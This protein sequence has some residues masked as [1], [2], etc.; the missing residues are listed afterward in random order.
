[1]DT[2]RTRRP[3]AGASKLTISLAVCLAVASAG[4]TVLRSAANPELVA[5][6]EHG[7][8]IEISDA[9]ESLID[10]GRDT[11][12]DREYAWEAV[13]A[14]PALTAPDLFARA[15]VGGRLVQSKGLRGAPLL[16]EVEE[17]ARQ[18]RTLDPDFRNS[19]ATRLLGTLYVMAP[20]KFLRHGNSETGI[21]LLE[22]LTGKGP[23]VPE[24]QLRLAEAYVSLSDADSARPHLCRCLEHKAA[25]R[26]D[27]QHLLTHLIEEIGTPE[28]GGVGEG[29]PPH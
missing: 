8:A 18:S 29:T 25:L 12:A 5:A 15:A 21:D 7:A 10:K 11:P 19:A 28:C 24:N 3:D 26:P 2:E 27:D 6:S 22:E 17:F 20:A 9:L 23:D 4:C 1:M 13:K 16:A 14:R